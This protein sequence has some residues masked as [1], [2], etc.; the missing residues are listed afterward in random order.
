[1][2]TIDAMLYF[3]D[4]DEISEDECTSIIKGTRYEKY[5]GNPSSQLIE[6]LLSDSSLGKTKV[7]IK[8]KR[9]EDSNEI[10]D[11]NIDI[12]VFI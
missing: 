10:D 7:V 2:N 8:Y 11:C 5:S 9:R 1:M 6:T 3:N 12:E 4:E